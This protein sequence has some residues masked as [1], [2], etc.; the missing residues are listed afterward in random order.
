MVV[1]AVMTC[2][3]RVFEG[4]ERYVDVSGLGGHREN[5]L[6]IATAKALIETHKGNVIAVFHQIVLLGKGKSILSC[7]KMEHY[8]AE[9]NDKSLRIPGGKQRIVMDGYQIPPTFCNGLAYLKCRPPTDAE[10][11]SL[12]H[13][14]M[15]ADVDWDPTSNDNVISDLDKFYDQD[16]DEVHHGNFDAHGNYLHRTVA[17]HLVQPE[18]E[19][20][21]VHKF[22]AFDDH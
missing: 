18:P 9:I 17:T 19:F 15:T 7:L 6:R 8:G 22:L 13:L 5:Q 10:V 4:G 21:D 20:F 2:D 3:M 11:D 14:I 16:I 1:Y 12:P